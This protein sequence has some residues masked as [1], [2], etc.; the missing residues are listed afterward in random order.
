MEKKWIINNTG[1]PWTSI[2]Q[3]QGDQ[4]LLRN[5]LFGITLRIV[6]EKGEYRI[7]R[8]GFDRTNIYFRL[9]EEEG[10]S[11]IALREVIENEFMESGKWTDT[12]VTKLLDYGVIHGI[13]FR[14]DSCEENSSQEFLSNSALKAM[15]NIEN[16]EYFFYGTREDGLTDKE[17]YELLKKLID[18]IKGGTPDLS[19]KLM[20]EKYKRIVEQKRQR[21]SE[22]EGENPGELLTEFLKQHPD[23]TGQMLLE[24][25]VRRGVTVDDLL[26]EAVRLGATQSGLQE[27]STKVND[28]AQQEVLIQGGE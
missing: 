1:E 21:E 16:D 28:G 14:R 25:A 23:I 11:I 7:I 27:A 19:I 22:K 4:T 8:V 12:D 10:I 13:C 5:N 17:K 2:D 24:E 18:D 26:V 9:M 15:H 6:A 20:Y 3:I